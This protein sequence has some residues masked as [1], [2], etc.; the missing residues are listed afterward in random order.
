MDDRR[1]RRSSN[2]IR[3][4]FAHFCTILLTLVS[5]SCKDS[6]QLFQPISEPTSF[7]SA[8]LPLAIGN[9]WHYVDTLDSYPY[10]YTDS[11]TR[12]RKDGDLYWWS[13]GFGGQEFAV[14]NDT[15]VYAPSIGETLPYYIPN[16]PPGDTVHLHW[17][18]ELDVRVYSLPGIV[19]VPA[20]S[21]ENCAAYEYDNGYAIVLFV[22]KPG[23]G[24]LSYSSFRTSDSTRIDQSLLMQYSLVH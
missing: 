16:P 9:S 20:G 22:F 8:L 3:F 21:F 7:R 12:F 19:V 1:S 23:V 14:R 13:I 2:S 24:V 6:V 10:Q 4:A 15:I 11:V 5:L 17:G 18:Y